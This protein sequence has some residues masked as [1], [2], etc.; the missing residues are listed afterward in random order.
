MPLNNLPSEVVAQL[1]EHFTKPVPRPQAD[2]FPAPPALF[3][4]SSSLAA[5]ARTSKHLHNHTLEKLY[6][7][8]SISPVVHTSTGSTHASVIS[9]A[10]AILDSPRSSEIAPL[11]QV[12]HICWSANLS[13]GQTVLN[14]IAACRNISYLSIDF[15]HRGDDHHE[16]L[17]L[18]ELL[19]VLETMPKLQT[20]NMRFTQVDTK[21]DSL[22]TP[23]CLRLRLP[24]LISL[25]IKGVPTAALDPEVV[26]PLPSLRHLHIDHF[27]LPS[28]HLVK[29]IELVTA[30]TELQQ[31]E[32]VD[33]E[34]PSDILSLLPSRIHTSV[35][36]LRIALDDSLLDLK[37]LSKFKVLQ[38]LDLGYSGFS[39]QDLPSLPSPLVD[40]TFF[41]STLELLAALAK[42][43]R[44]AGYLPSLKRVH[45]TGADD[46]FWDDGEASAE[47]WAAALQ[48]LATFESVLK[49]RGI[50]LSPRLWRNELEERF[51][52]EN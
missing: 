23:A 8:V 22:Y 50:M 26:H 36:K 35:K 49:S 51:S 27:D 10:R 15:E 44:L 37:A 46:A 12:L 4:D 32:L 45:L 7:H 40:L 3:V 38:V 42:A 52:P 1:L 20:L 33:I 47:E 9:L 19:E 25:R 5:L 6:R 18:E 31:L 24:H 29:Y 28:A 39:G 34:E 43:L 11:V 30:E 21:Y 41:P 13:S 48:T 14:I 2:E 17:P 16:R